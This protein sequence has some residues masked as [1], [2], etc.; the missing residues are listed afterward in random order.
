MS[1]RTFVRRLFGSDR[2]WRVPDRRRRGA[3]P[4]ALEALEERSML[5]ASGVPGAGAVVAHRPVGIPVDLA[6][7]SAAGGHPDRKGWSSALVRRRRA[8]PGSD[9]AVAGSWTRPTPFK[10]PGARGPYV[11]IHMSV[12]PNGMVL[13]WPHDYNYFLKYRHAAPYTPDIMLWDPATNT[14]HPLPVLNTNIFCSGSTFLP[15]GDLIIL[16]G[17]GPSAIPTGALQTHYGNH[18]VEIYDYRTNTWS[19]G[20]NMA[21][22]RYYGSAITLG[23]GQV[24]AV[25]GYNEDGGNDPLIELYTPGQGWRTLSAATTQAFPDWYPNIYQLSNGLVFGA[26]PGRHTFFIDPNGAGQIGRGPSM[27]YPRRYDGASVM[28]AQDQIL[29][30]GGDAARGSPPTGGSGR[31]ITNTAEII[32]LDSPNPTWQYTGSMHFRRYLLNATLLPDGTVL[33]TGGTS[34][35]DN[36]NGNALRGAVYAAELWDPKTGQWT[37]LSSMR[38]PRLYHSTAVLLPDGRVLVAGGGEP[39]S[40]GEAKGTVHQTMQIFSP[41]YLFRGPQPVITSAPASAGY[42]QT[43]S[44]TSPDAASIATINLIRPGSTTHGFNMTQRIV[45]VPFTREADGTLELQMPTNPNDAPPGPYM[46][47]LLNNL[48]V[49]SKAAMMFLTGS[50]TPT[51]P[52]SPAVGGDSQAW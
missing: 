14:Y 28:Y 2:G 51:A 3:A 7:S 45:N 6:E 16:G 31:Q 9:S 17:N 10:P 8:A 25:A 41:P 21:E 40:T 12:L 33:A 20:P 19:R 36:N 29:A 22:G 46:L 43:I 23:N 50:S 42:G 24:I 38:V 15:N 35:P 34:Q 1:T 30:I 5:S 4:I 44:V 47:F 48:G 27:N 13:S 26:N 11:A 49:P 32:N 18:F 37:T 39:E 52:V